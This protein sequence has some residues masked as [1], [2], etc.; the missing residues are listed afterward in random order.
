MINSSA[1]N[2]YVI[3]LANKTAY[4]QRKYETNQMN[5]IVKNMPSFNAH[6]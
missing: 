5:Y 2:P 4:T 3:Q 6:S 1:S